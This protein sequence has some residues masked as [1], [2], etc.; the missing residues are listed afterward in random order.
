MQEAD[1]DRLDTGGLQRS[2]SRFDT[3]GLQL[4][5]HVAGCK[6]PLVDFADQMAID[7]RPMLMEQEIIGFRPVAATDR[8]DVAGAAGDD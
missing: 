5:M 1:R 4:F 3:G 7:Q 6:Q 8:V 2:A